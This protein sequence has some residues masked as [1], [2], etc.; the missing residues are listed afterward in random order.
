MEI[1][2]SEGPWCLTALLGN[3]F[4]QQ[5]FRQKKTTICFMDS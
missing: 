1:F 5:S 2:G 4:S 3:I